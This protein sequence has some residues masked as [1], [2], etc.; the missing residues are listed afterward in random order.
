MIIERKIAQRTRELFGEGVFGKHRG[1]AKDTTLGG[2]NSDASLDVWPVAPSDPALATRRAGI[3]TV[4]R[5]NSF[6]LY[7][8]NAP[9]IIAEDI[10][11]SWLSGI[12]SANSSTAS[13]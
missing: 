6:G 3:Y 7:S 13:I 1:L 5:A 9:Y 10:T 2:P 11:R 4:W 8:V 12:W